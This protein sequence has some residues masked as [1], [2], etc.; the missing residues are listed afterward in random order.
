MH[1]CTHTH[2]QN[3]VSEEVGQMRLRED[4][5]RRD[6]MAFSRSLMSAVWQQKESLIWGN[7]RGRNKGATEEG[8]MWL[9]K[10]EFTLLL[11]SS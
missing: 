11:W 5:A 3:E 6:S 9:E 1:A 8:F 4:R 10:R 7:S 2:M